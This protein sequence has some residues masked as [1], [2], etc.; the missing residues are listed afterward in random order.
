[1]PRGARFPVDAVAQ[2]T[3]VLRTMRGFAGGAARS[4]RGRVDVG[5]GYLRSGT[6]S[7]DR[8]VEKIP[9]EIAI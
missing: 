5:E 9:E 7:A 6:V 8:K 2:V 4:L 3:T 1:M